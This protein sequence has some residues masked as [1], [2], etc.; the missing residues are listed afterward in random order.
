MVHWDG[1]TLSINFEVSRRVTHR[2]ASII[3]KI[4]LTEVLGYSGVSIIEMDDKFRVPE[5]IARLNNVTYAAVM[6]L[7]DEM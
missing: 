3:M 7:Q 6:Y 4:F 5:T 2:L 1:Q